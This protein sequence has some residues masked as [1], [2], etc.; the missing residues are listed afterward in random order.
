[1]PSRTRERTSDLDHASSLVAQ[2]AH[3]VQV[4]QTPDPR[5][6]DFVLEG[7]SRRIEADSCSFLR[8]HARI[9]P[10]AFSAA[11]RALCRAPSGR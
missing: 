3:L 1:M 6:F 4:A 8:G 7:D 2:R 9:E 5:R 10:R 11:R